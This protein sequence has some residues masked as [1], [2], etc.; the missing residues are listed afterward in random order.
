MLKLD[1]NNIKS[2]L[3]SF[4]EQVEIVKDSVT[5]IYIELEYD[6]VYDAVSDLKAVADTLF[7]FVVGI[8]KK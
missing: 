2:I 7:D 4:T 1:V 5:G 6:D 3:R 8:E